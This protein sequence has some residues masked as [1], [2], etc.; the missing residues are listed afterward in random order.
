MTD[1][2]IPAIRMAVEEFDRRSA[3]QWRFAEVEFDHYAFLPEDPDPAKLVAHYR[4]AFKFAADLAG[5][6]ESARRTLVDA[7]KTAIAKAAP[8]S[9]RRWQN[10]CVTSDF[11]DRDMK[12]FWQALEIVLEHYVA[13]LPGDPAKL[14]EHYREMDLFAFEFVHQLGREREALGRALDASRQSATALTADDITAF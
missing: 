14:V 10:F 1:D 4:D 5:K 12:A 8:P 13:H 3:L 9:E 11:F 7:V 6:F 2:A